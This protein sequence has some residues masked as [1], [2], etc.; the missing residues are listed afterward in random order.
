MAMETKQYSGSERRRM[1]A[2]LMFAGLLSPICSSSYFPAM[3]QVT[4]ELATERTITDLTITSYLVMMGLAPVVWGGFG[5]SFGR[6]RLLVAAGCVVVVASVGCGLATNVVQLIFL[7]VLQAV[8]TSAA[9]VLGFGVIADVYPREERGTAVGLYSMGPLLGQL[10]GPIIGGVVT[11]YASWKHIFFSLAGMGALSV[12]SILI[13]LPETLVSKKP[14]PLKSTNRF[15]F[16]IR[17]GK[18]PNPFGSLGFLLYAKVLLPTLYTVV[19]FVTFYY[20]ILS[21]NN[22][23]K[24]Y[25]LDTMQLGLTYIPLGIADIV[26]ALFGGRVS[27][28]SLRIAKRRYPEC[29]PEARL[30]LLPITITLIGSGMVGIS[31]LLEANA[32][33]YLILAILMVSCIC[34]S[35]SFVLIGTYIMDLFPTNAASTS[36]AGNLLR[37]LAAAGLSATTTTISKAFPLKTIF[38]AIGIAQV[39]GLVLA[40]TLVV[41]RNHF[42]HDYLPPPPQMSPA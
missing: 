5:D 11:H 10:L 3:E 23:L 17:V 34:I 20:I 8:G 31:F 7:R 21:Q 32:N 16:V 2:V 36:A 42:D 14:S 29:P 38:L 37:I 40:A 30:L 33:M 22:T 26:G 15:P 1:L 18:L 24:A 13:F 19:L 28:L 12:L 39:S 35:I 6:R 41:C 25:S 27:D 4:Q 9:T